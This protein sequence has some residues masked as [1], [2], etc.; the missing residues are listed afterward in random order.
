MMLTITKLAG[1]LVLLLKAL[2]WVRVTPCR[3]QHLDF[4]EELYAAQ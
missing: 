4:R 3:G 2:L 1:Y